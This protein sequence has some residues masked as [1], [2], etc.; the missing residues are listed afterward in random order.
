MLT[1]Y[2]GKRETQESLKVRHKVAYILSALTYNKDIYQMLEKK[3]IDMSEYVLKIS[4]IAN[5]ESIITTLIKLLTQKIGQLS[6][7]T[8]QQ[9]ESSHIKQLDN[10]TI[11]I[12]DIK[13]EDG[14]IY[15]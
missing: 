2:Y 11:H 4:Q 12:F 3:K 9:I 15:I 5:Q 7:E 14:N 13:N 10:L 1:F 8:I 6:N